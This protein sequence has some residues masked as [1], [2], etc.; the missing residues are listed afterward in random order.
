[1]QKN[2][3]SSSVLYGSETWPLFIIEEY[4]LQEYKH[5]VLALGNIFRLKRN[6]IDR[7]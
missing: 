4:E 2:T 3:T 7:E 1:M 6:K 5:E